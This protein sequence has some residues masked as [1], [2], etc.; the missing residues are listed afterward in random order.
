MSQYLP[1]LVDR[2]LD[3][4]L[5]GVPAIVLEGPNG[6]GKT[7]TS[8][9]QARTTDELDRPAHRALFEVDPLRLGSDPV[10]VLLD[11]WQRLPFV[12]DST[13]AAH[14][15][16]LSD[17]WILDPLPAWTPSDN[18]LHRLAQAPR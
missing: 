17:R 11:E 3:E 5:T 2:E 12:W 8:F 1:P 14:R 6:V 16:V 7:A 18:R 15:H 4:L 13:T 9:L 10:P